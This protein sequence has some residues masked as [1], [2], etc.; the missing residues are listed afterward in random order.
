MK[1]RRAPLPSCLLL[2]FIGT[3][4]AV[5]AADWPYY[6]HDAEH[7]GR[8]TAV[9]DAAKLMLSWTAPDGYATPQIVGGTIYSTKSQG[10]YSGTRD[11]G[12]KWATYIT[13][14]D[15]QTGA[16]K[17]TH[18]GNDVF[19]SQAAVGGGLVVFH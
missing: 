7:T 10:G 6:Q 15:L 8:S 12:T 9:I 1:K 3:I 17:W 18:S 5:Q 16:I 2:L 13:A 19:C 4:V 14:F 11:D